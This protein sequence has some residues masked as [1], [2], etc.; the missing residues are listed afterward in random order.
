MEKNAETGWEQTQEQISDYLA[1]RLDDDAREAFELRMFTDPA[2]SIEVERA[3]E[4]RSALQAETARP[5]RRTIQWM[6]LAA[7]AAVAALA[8]ALWP[9]QTGIDIEM[10]PDDTNSSTLRGEPQPW[11]VGIEASGE[12]LTVSWAPVPGTSSYELIVY[13]EDGSVVLERTIPGDQTST[14]IPVADAGDRK[15]LLR[16]RALDSF[17]NLRADSGLV[18]LPED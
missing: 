7:A 1:G 16:L 8:I 10:P 12:T 13:L 5:G 3:A 14:R 9:G 4:L 17:N 18:A 2:L 6:P 15:R 11:T